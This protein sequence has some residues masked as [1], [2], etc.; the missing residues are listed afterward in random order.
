MP[1]SKMINEEQSQVRFLRMRQAVTGQ[2]KTPSLR[3]L[4]VL[5]VLCVKIVLAMDQG[6]KAKATRKETHI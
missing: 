1:Q 6:R 3:T 5:G 2:F 4:R